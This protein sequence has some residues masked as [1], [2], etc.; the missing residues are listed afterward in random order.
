MAVTS[1]RQATAGSERWSSFWRELCREGRPQE[2]CHVPGDGREVVDRHWAHFAACLP[3]GARVID[4]GCGAGIVG[5]KLLGH[6]SDL[7]V[8]GVDW[9]RV[10]TPSHANLDIHMSVSME[11]L[12]F[13]DSSFDAAVSLF[14]IEY[15]NV[16]ETTA[17]LARVLRP[18][19]LFSFL[20]HHRLSE[21]VR[22]GGARRR[23]LRELI[24][25]T[26]KS[27]FLSGSAAGVERQRRALRQRFPDE[28]MVGLVSDYF[29]RNIVRPRAERQATWQ[30][31]AN[32]LDLEISLLRE[33][34][35]SAKSEAEM[36]AWLAPFLS[37]LGL[38]S[39]AV[40][41]RRS[42][43]PIAWNV[44]GVR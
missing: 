37:N 19:A 23:A 11:S 14:G 1:V 33:L 21:I 43:E 36:A 18:G 39:V 9:A 34:E 31:L 44:S 8:T 22:E 38:T 27:A 42:G 16:L 29:R 17:E 41:R 6:R 10:P 32:D 13:G 30:K 2:R 20:V 26:M 5:R 28:P 35:R 15:G 7:K 24:S 12:P 4:L 40:L 3:W 25:G